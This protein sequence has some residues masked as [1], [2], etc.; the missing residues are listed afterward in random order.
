MKKLF[1]GVGILVALVGLLWGASL[2]I[3][4]R[5]VRMINLSFFSSPSQMG[6]MIYS[7]LRQE[8]LGVRVLAIGVQPESSF[9]QMAVAGFLRAWRGDAVGGESAK[10]RIFVE[11]GLPWSEGPPDVPVE[12]LRL[13]SDPHEIWGRVQNAQKNSER[14]IL[15]THA[16]Y[17]THVLAGNP[18]SRLEAASGE[19]IPALTL[20][21][22]AATTEELKDLEPRCVGSA[23]DDLGLADLG[24]LLRQRSTWYGRKWLKKRKELASTH[25][26][27]AMEMLGA[28]DYLVFTKDRATT[29]AVLER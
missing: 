26:A 12:S 15:Y 3:G 10:L 5:P 13:K 16:Y 24:C 21:N 25:Y 11:E 8:M 14:V 1:I 6:S 19:R 17:T 2:L 18:I 20:V 28:R 27:A 4:P 29:A 22:F 9:H 7:R 23:R